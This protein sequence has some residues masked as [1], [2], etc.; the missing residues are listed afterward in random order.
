MNPPI[1]PESK[2]LHRET[3]T[4]NGWVGKEAREEEEEE[5][6]AKVE[7]NEGGNEVIVCRASIL[8]VRLVSGKYRAA[9][10]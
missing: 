10:L 1:A 3:E 8:R 6:E 4:Q 2:S 7:D 5:R 9:T